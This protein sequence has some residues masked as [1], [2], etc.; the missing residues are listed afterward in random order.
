P[1][2][3][4]ESVTWFSGFHSIANSFAQFAD[5]MMMLASF[6]TLFLI[7]WI[8]A[9]ARL[10]TRSLF[11]S[12]EHTSELQSRFDLVCRLLLEKKN[13]LLRLQK[14]GGAPLDDVQW[15]AIWARRRPRRRLRSSAQLLSVCHGNPRVPRTHNATRR[16]AL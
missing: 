2:R 8:L 10:R 5:P 4:G 9:D 1:P 6:T 16:Q 3:T 13:Y 15:R 12:E 7:G 14:P 11:R